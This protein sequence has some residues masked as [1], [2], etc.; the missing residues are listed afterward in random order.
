[1]LRT[2]NGKYDG[3]APKYGTTS[4]TEGDVLQSLAVV[5]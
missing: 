2:T 4:R 5:G 1:M 3:R